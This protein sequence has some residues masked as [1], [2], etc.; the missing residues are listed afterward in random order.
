MQ[1]QKHRLRGSIR[2]IGLAAIAMTM[3]EACHRPGAEESS[4]TTKGEAQAT[5]LPTRQTTIDP[6][7]RKLDAAQQDNERRRTEIDGATR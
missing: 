4:S 1:R 5:P 7:N 2:S 3:L 6:V